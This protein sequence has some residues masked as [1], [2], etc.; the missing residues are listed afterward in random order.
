MNFDFTNFDRSKPPV[1]SEARDFMFPKY[2][3]EKLPNGIKIFV[4]E[5]KKLPLITVKFVVK[6]GTY[7]DDSFGEDKSGLASITS[8]LLIKGTN[9]MDAI[10][11]AEEID[12][13]GATI[14]SGCE[15]DGSYLALTSLG[16]YF[17]KLFDIASSCIISPGFIED[18]IAREKQQ[19]KN[20]LLSF[21]DEGSFLSERAFKKNVY[22]NSPYR[23][24]IEGNINTIEKIERENIFDFFTKYYTPENLIISIVGDIGRDEALS[25]IKSRFKDL[26]KSSEVI[27]PVYKETIGTGIKVIAVEKKG[28]VQSDIMVGHLAVDRKNPDYIPMVVMN[29]LLGGFFT[30][31]INKNLREV[32]GYTYGARS[33]FNFRKHLGDF[34]V[35]TNVENSLTY[36]AIKEIIYE[37]NKLR[38]ENITE[39]ELNSVKNYLTGS[40][41]LQ[42]ETPNSIANKIINL[43]LFDINKDFY[44]TYISK[45]NSVTIQ[46]VRA[47]TEKYIHPENLVISVAGN[48]D[49]IKKTMEQ[50]ENIEVINNIEEL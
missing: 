46:D 40:F 38:D 3:E 45:V 36:K 47:V 50:Y 37:I 20:S 6:A 32:N 16:K 25:L 39:D 33:Y 23:L 31:R 34:C 24:N 19:I 48:T 2:Y 9:E 41:P 17:P 1:V 43:E 27:L 28:A 30:S 44:D 21:L 22:K 8:D 14:S 35:E 49:V 5:D 42:L 13:Y 26:K 11:V 7:N 4:V 12:F 18:E 10:K 15:Y 29:T